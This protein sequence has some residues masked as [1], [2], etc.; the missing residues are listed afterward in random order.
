M[1]TKE[2]SGTGSRRR[3]QR[4]ALQCV[5]GVGIFHILHTIYKSHFAGV[6]VPNVE[7]DPQTGRKRTR[8]RPERHGQ[9]WNPDQV[10]YVFHPKL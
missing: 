6:F 3:Q 8:R 10:T 5:I 9:R 2:N 1:S 7:I 4:Q